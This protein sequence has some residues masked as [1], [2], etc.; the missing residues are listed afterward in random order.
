MQDFIK[1]G[2]DLDRWKDETLRLINE[3]RSRI[4]LDVF[5]EEQIFQIV[6]SVSI[7]KI[8]ELITFIEK[9]TNYNTYAFAMLK[10]AKRII[11]L[12]Q[13]KAMVILSDL[14][15]NKNGSFLSPDR[16][17]AGK[18]DHEIIRTILSI[19][20]NFGKKFILQSYI[21]QNG[22]YNDSLI[23]A[24]DK[25]LFYEDYFDDLNVPQAYFKANLQYN[26]GLAKGLPIKGND[27]VFIANHKGKMTLPEII[28]KYLVGLF[29]CPVVKIREAT[30]QSLFDLVS[31]NT[32]YLNQL[33]RFGIVEGTENQVE[34]SLIVLNALALEKS[35]VLIHLKKELFQIS[36][37]KKH[38]NILESISEVLRLV[39]TKQNG[40]LSTIEINTLKMLTQKSPIILDRGF[41]SIKNGRNFLYSKYQVLL[42][43]KINQNELDNTEIQND[44]YSSL[45]KK[46]YESYTADMEGEVHRGYN[47]NSN[48][49]T[50]E[51]QSPYYDEVKSSLN[52]VF[53]D[54]VK[55]DVSKILLSKELIKNFVYMIPQIYFIKSD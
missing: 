32:K 8:S 46:G 10:I 38:F 15:G 19:N 12:E 30:L 14:A 2:F 21:S 18:I 13:E 17:T 20:K 29:N 26:E 1:N 3:P 4:L 47:I 41:T 28:I 54:K 27:Y 42:M 16:Y 34:Y 44:V 48:F 45:V 55:G 33:F 51:I 49:D 25:L 7:L 52:Y 50:I 6:D 11:S 53:L 5:S 31:D 37:S 40:F 43:G 24:I 23:G 22:K 35:E 39:N 36:A 9:W